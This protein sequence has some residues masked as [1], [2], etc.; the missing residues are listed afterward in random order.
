MNNVSLL[1]F[2][3]EDESVDRIGIS[4][5]LITRWVGMCIFDPFLPILASTRTIVSYAYDVLSSK[6]DRFSASS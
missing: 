1:T 2:N 6:V 3:D 4:H 5:E